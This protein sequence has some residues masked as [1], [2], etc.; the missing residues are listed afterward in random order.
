MHSNISR[1]CI[2]NAYQPD[3]CIICVNDNFFL[4]ELVAQK[5]IDALVYMDSNNTTF[6]N[7][8]ILSLKLPSEAAEIVQKIIEVF[9][10]DE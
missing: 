3:I 9:D 7:S 2:N 6:Q 5:K 8:G 10:N 4:E 1:E